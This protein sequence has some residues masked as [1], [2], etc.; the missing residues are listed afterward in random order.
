MV[1]SITDCVTFTEEIFVFPF[2]SHSFF[3]TSLER[4]SELLLLYAVLQ[5]AAFNGEFCPRRISAL[6][7]QH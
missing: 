4:Y 1:S 6:T 7:A 2:A 5:T 3:N